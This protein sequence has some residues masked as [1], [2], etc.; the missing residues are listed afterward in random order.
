[1][2]KI[3]F[4]G[5]LYPVSIDLISL[6]T[7]SKWYF[8]SF[9][10]LT[11]TIWFEVMIF[12]GSESVEEDVCCLGLRFNGLNVFGT[13]L[14]WKE[15]LNV[16]TELL[17]FEELDEDDVLFLPLRAL[18]PLIGLLCFF[19]VLCFSSA[20]SFPWSAFLHVLRSLLY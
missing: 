15:G 10:W 17:D 7:Y 19:I 2:R 8:L 20:E 12:N 4:Q 6:K 13:F 11:C 14:W 16:W 9:S 3:D 18:L 5:R 1:M